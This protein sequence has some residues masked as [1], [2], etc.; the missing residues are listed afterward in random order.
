VSFVCTRVTA[1]GNPT[2]ATRAPK[3]TYHVQSL[4]ARRRRRWKTKRVE[5]ALARAQLSGEL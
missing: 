5:S 4:T 1:Q 3:M 2:P